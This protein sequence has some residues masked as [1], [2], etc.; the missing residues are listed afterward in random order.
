MTD[1]DGDGRVTL[2]DYEALVLKSLKQQGI[3]LD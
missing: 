3:S 2:E 1:T